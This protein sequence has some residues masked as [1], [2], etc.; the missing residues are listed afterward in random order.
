MEKNRIIISAIF[1]AVA[2]GMSVAVLVLSVMGVN[3]IESSITMLSI[4][5]LALALLSLQKAEKK[6]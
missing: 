1:K 4:G 6:K 5:L 2:F 3:T